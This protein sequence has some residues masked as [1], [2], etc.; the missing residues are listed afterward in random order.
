[1]MTGATW[2]AI[3]LPRLA[4]DRLI[5]SGRAPEG[6]P[7]ATYAKEA[8][9]F[10][11]TGVDARA[12]ALGLKLAMS[13]ADARAIHPNLAALEAEPEEDARM[14]DHIAAWCERFTPVVSVDAP[15]GLFL[16][17]TGCGHLFGDELALRDQIV[18]RL[19]AQGFA[20]RAALAPT[21]GAAW[22]IARY[23]C[24]ADTQT[25][26]LAHLAPLPIEALRL[27]ERSLVPVDL[28]PAQRA[29]DF[30]DPRLGGAL[31]VGILDAKDES[32]AVVARVEV[33]E[34]SGA[35]AAHVE[36]A[37]RAWSEARSYGRHPAPANRATAQ[38]PTLVRGSAFGS[39]GNHA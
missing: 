4:T 12:S 8:N 19:E 22:A 18:R 15:D 34:Q 37:G 23:G 7:L 29:D 31:P 10:L 33:A 30:V 28:E 21:P 25:A 2:L 5:R 11:L 39:P 24:G 26:L 9:A 1:L 32:P 6:R 17:I 16:D 20:C 38:A 3:F 36:R 35:H 13:L 14:L 27:E